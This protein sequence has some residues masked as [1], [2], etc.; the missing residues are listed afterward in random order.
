M[1]IRDRVTD[2][3]LFD[4]Y[5]KNEFVD[6]ITNLNNRLYTDSLTGT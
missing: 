1:C 6:T 5:G 4:A 3:T 2:E